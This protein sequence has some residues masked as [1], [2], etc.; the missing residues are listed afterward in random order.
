MIDVKEIRPLAAVKA[1]VQVPGS[2][3][4]TQRALVAA[5]LAEG[6]S[7]LRNAL[8]A[9][10]TGH[11]VGALRLLGAQIV[12]SGPDVIV[13]GTGG[14]IANPGRELYLGSNGTAMRFL[15]GVAA[16][17][18]GEITLTGDARLCERPLKPLLDAIGSLGVSSECRNVPGYPPVTIRGGTMHGGRAVFQDIESSQYVSSIL[19][20]APYAAG[21][22]EVEIRGSA[23]SRPYV[24]M[25][26]ATMKAFGVAVEKRSE[27][28]F[29]VRSGQ[30]YRACRY[31]VEGDLSSASYFFLAAALC[32]GTVRVANTNFWTHQG[33]VRFLRF[34]KEL[35]C[36]VAATDQWIEVSGGR[37]APGDFTASME[38]VPDMVPT[39]AV[40]A[41]LRPGRTFIRNVPH[42][43]LKESN[44]L[45]AL[46]S[47]LSKTGIRAAELED[48]LVVTGGT[49]RGAE[50]ET[51][52]DH[53]IAMS[54]AVLGLAAPGMRIRNP[55]CV[56]KSF[57]GFWDE[58]EKLY[59][60]A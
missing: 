5:S 16:T 49:P 32:G 34:L 15:A 50:I 56:G 46:V 52:N 30:R 21:D 59:R 51:Y 23:V 6:T 40:L 60:A 25:T 14:R 44:R 17:G 57:P 29:T 39:M 10:D 43:R 22:V 1:A 24:E 13:T 19:L 28:L 55:G 27:A 33:D 4:F 54:F 48:G 2:K 11:L 53:R 45:A 38:D 35:G 41:A 7:L 9:E 12:N 3:S 36:G 58:L 42:L 8:I 47:E 20:A 31:L 37:L 18:P 26:L